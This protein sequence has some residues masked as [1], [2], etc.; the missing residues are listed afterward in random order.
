MRPGAGLSDPKNLKLGRLVILYD[1]NKISLDGKLDM[2]FTENVRQ[3]FTA[4][5]W[6]TLLLEN[7]N[8]VADI[9]SALEQAVQETGRPTLIEVRTTIG[10]GAPHIGGTNKVHGNPLGAEEVKATK[11]AYGWHHEPFF[12][13]GEVR[14]HFQALEAHGKEAEVKWQAL[15]A[16]YEQAYPKLATELKAAIDGKLPKMIRGS[17]YFL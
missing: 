5:G 1:S 15:F 3:R 12:V 7:G 8:E 2:S 6:Q 4:Y 14:A 9:Q 16:D 10:Y 11:E 17:Y 13:P